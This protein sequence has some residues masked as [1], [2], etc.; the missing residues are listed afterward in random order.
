MREAWERAIEGRLSSAALSEVKKPFL[1]ETEYNSILDGL[2]SPDRVPAVPAVAV[3]LWIVQAKK[4]ADSI[5]FC[6]RLG[7]SVLAFNW[8]GFVE[9]EFCF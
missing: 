4:V 8:H 3:F 5:P 9:L 6:P 1:A 7:I 2:V